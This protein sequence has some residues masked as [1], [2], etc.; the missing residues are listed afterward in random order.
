[1]VVQVVIFSGY[2]LLDDESSLMIAVIAFTARTI[3]LELS[4]K[5]VRDVIFS[6]HLIGPNCL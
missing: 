2:I 4:Q 6:G 5:V 1:M 3:T